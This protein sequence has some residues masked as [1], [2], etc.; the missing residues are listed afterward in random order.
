[1][2][3]LYPADKQFYTGFQNCVPCILTDTVWIAVE[4]S[5]TSITVLSCIVRLTL[6]LSCEILAVIT[7]ASWLLTQALHT[8]RISIIASC[9]NI[10]TI[11]VK[12]FLTQ[13]LT[14]RLVTNLFHCTNSITVTHLKTVT[15][16][17]TVRL[18]CDNK[19]CEITV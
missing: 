18:L 8:V 2:F 4:S 19:Y 14:V 9:T 11:S 10:T 16:I 13:T 6:T 3:Q 15:E 1:M 12:H 17:R 7:R 5:S